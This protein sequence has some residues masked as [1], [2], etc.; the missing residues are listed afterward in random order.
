MN[1]H[2]MLFLSCLT[3]LPL[4]PLAAHGSERSTAAG[5]VAKAP[6]PPLS[7]TAA[8]AAFQIQDGYRVELAACEPDVVDPTFVAFDEAGRMWVVEMP[9][10][11]TGGPDGKGPKG[12][13]KILTD[14]DGDGRY[15]LAS[16]FADNLSYVHGV[17]PW[18]GGVI[19]A[20]APHI[21]Y[22]A[23]N[24]GDGRMDS[25]EVW[26]TGFSTTNPQLYVNTPT[27]A[28]DNW[29]YV[30]NGLRGGNVRDAR[31]PSAVLLSIRDRDF[32]FQPQTGEYEAVAGGA[33]YGLSFDSWGNRFICSNRNHI[34]HVVMELHYLERVPYLPVTRP[35]LDIPDHG[36]AAR[37][38]TISSNWTTSN[39]HRGTF[40]A[41]C[42]LSI[43]VGDLMPELAGNAF[44]C[45][46]TANV[47]HRDLLTPAGVTFVATRV[48]TD[49]EFLASRDD[50]FRPVHTTTGPDGAL[51]IV[52][53]YR[54]VIEHP[55]FMPPELKNRPDLYSGNRLGRI[56]RIVPENRPGKPVRPLPHDPDRLIELLGHPNGWVRR[57][58]HRLLLQLGP[59]DSEQ[60]LRR[61]ARQAR[62]PAR[63]HALWV[64]E[65]TD[66]LTEEDVL[67][68]L[69]AKDPHLVE[70]AIKLVERRCRPVTNKTGVRLPEPVW[71]QARARIVQLLDHR[72]VRVRYQAL[73][74]LGYFPEHVHIKRF[75]AA[76]ARDGAD[77][78]LR[79]AVAS[80]AGKQAWRLLRALSVLKRWH[81][82]D[83]DTRLAILELLGTLI[84]GAGDEAPVREALTA[85]VR[86][87]L[88]IE[89]QELI[90]F[91][92]GIASGLAR[93][94]RSPRTMLGAPWAAPLAA[95]LLSYA[96]D[97]DPKQ[98][99]SKVTTELIRL[100]GW[101]P[102]E[103]AA[104]RLASWIEMTDAN[105]Q[106]RAAAIQAIGLHRDEQAVSVLL[107]RWKALLPAE[108]RAAAAVL[109][110]NRNRAMRLL[111]AIKRGQVAAT[112][113]DKARLQQLRNYPDPTVRAEARRVLAQL[114]PA[115]RQKV[116]EQYR[117]AL[118]LE[119]NF[120]RG[121]EIFR[122]KCASCHR[123]AG[124]GADV[125]P[126]ISDT[127]IRSAESL[128]TDIL[129]PN[130]AIDA[131]YVN[132]VVLTRD[133]QVYTGII[134][135][136]TATAITLVRGANEKSTI[137]KEQIES[138]RSTGQSLMPE[139]FEQELTPQD[140]AD[141]IFFLK[142]WRY[143]ESSKEPG[144]P[145]VPGVNR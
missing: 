61:V 117:V 10:Y 28:Y 27:F 51:Y 94:R 45:D 89:R 136:E 105:T 95:I 33:Q 22:L 71:S 120:Q 55:D 25:S 96:H 115:D 80:A 124:M 125:G 42:G 92:A 5:A 54:A 102:D 128:L 58:A 1:R 144:A 81:S 90:V 43:Y 52:D 11:P 101:L 21:V 77:P 29:I 74:T 59:R 143:L 140:L 19:A 20:M 86:G 4:T 2:T 107:G 3:L 68:A 129:D 67:A 12:R 135:G 84:G 70:H 121:K 31:K 111:E 50:W 114:R 14:P 126:D 97:V 88:G 83:P 134:A 113:L 40:T 72:S 132:Y 116:I 142:N 60:L 141:L 108:R 103:Q 23:D 62:P 119:G 100:L 78:W 106:F 65:G 32:R 145:P 122:H 91:T 56:W 139:G 36:A 123:V 13:I 137:L 63:M 30:A 64:L 131:N 109:L 18:R 44:V 82:A 87:E 127:R 34:R 17:Q 73:L 37:L 46:P 99:P 38:F 8:T 47:V 41:A 9:G 69:D 35:V 110:R 57:T 133:G 15:T 66:L 138:I 118:K 104:R 76:L 93:R 7:P 16:V 24:D 49:R 48:P 130:R 85:A 26:Y 79:L 75:A 98:P 39:L 6:R 112:E 53:M